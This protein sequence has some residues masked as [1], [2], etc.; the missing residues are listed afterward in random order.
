MKV[1]VIHNRYRQRGGEDSVFDSETALLRTCTDVDTWVVDNRD[2][3]PVLGDALVSL[4]L[5]G[6][7]A[8]YRET[9]RR[10]AKS[11]PDVVHVHN[12]F[13]QLTV[14]V[15]RACHDAGVPVVMTLHNFRIWC[16]AAT[17]FRSGQICEECVGH[18]PRRAL[19]YSCYRGS[20]FGTAAVVRAQERHIRDRVWQTQVDR[21]IALTRFS[22]DRAVAFGL[23]AEKIAVKPNFAPE[24]AVVRT[25]IGAKAVYVGRLSEEKGVS[26]AIEAFRKLPGRQLALIG[27]GPDEADLRRIAPANVTF[28]GPQPP[29]RVAQELAEAAFLVF[30]SLCYET[31]GRVLVEAMGAGIPV[32]ASRIGGTPEIVRDRETGL[33]FTPGSVDE[34]REVA[35]KLFVDRDMNANCGGAGRIAYEREYSPEV[36]RELLLGIYRDAI[37]K[38]ANLPTIVPDRGDSA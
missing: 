17:L 38:P 16:A 12:I 23:S 2:M 20:Y 4:R 3:I 6:S 29:G 31:F 24:P 5:P 35:E 22:K 19:D 11:R 25:A 10:L 13:P 18:G 26:V 33:L 36:N 8:R 32:I 30:P 14:S 15:F 28:L 27:S 9:R 7:S 37:T 21:F 34:L 1:L